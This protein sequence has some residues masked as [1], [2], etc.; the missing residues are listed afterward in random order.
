MIDHRLV[1]LGKLPY[2]HDSRNLQL[3]K[4]LVAAPPCPSTYDWLTK[5]SKFGPMGN[6]TA[7]DCVVAGAGHL[8]QMWT[9]NQGKEVIIPDPDILAVYSKLTGYDPVTGAN[10]NGL[11]LADFL[12]FWRQTGID[13][14]QIGAYVQ[15]DPANPQLMALACYF[16]GGVYCGLALPLSAQNQ[17]KWI[18]KG[19]PTNP[20]PNNPAAPGSWG[21]HCVVRGVFDPLGGIFISWGEEYYA[22]QDF[23]AAYFDEAYAIISQDFL[24]GKQETPLG[25]DLAALNADLQAV[26]S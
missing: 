6:L 12:K 20:D 25:F 10:D 15:V 14:H 3:A 16:F 21:G 2:K 7:G 19:D 4:Y 17:E 22:T 18:V 9:A 24:D 1:K 11:N 26:T 23:I 8:I 13:G 5:I